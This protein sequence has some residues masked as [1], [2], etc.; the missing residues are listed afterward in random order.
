MASRPVRGS[1]WCRAAAR[2]GASPIGD[3]DLR[4][5]V[6][7]L[8]VPRLAQRSWSGLK[9]VYDF[10]GLKNYL[11]LLADR[12]FHI[13]IRNTLLFTVPFV[14]GACCSGSSWPSCST[15]GFRARAFFRGI[16]LF[17]MA[18][19]LH[20]HR[21]RLALA[22]EPRHRRPA[23]PGSTCSST[24]LGLDFLQ[25][26]LVSRHPTGGSPPSPC[27]PSGRCPATP[28]RSILAGLRGIPEEAARGR[29]RGRR[30]RVCSLY[31]YVI[32]P[33]LRPVTLTALIIL[34]HISLKV[35]DLIVA[36]AGKQ[37]SRSTCPPSTCGRRPSTPRL[38]PGAAIAIFM[39]RHRGGARHPVPVYSSARRRAP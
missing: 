16:Y 9:P 28:W 29:P 8:V 5:R 13:D 22:D 30:Q 20:R 1:H 27:R 33:L 36:I 19:S 14:V 2:P 10:V 7:R 26:P 3:G 32:L 39:L 11:D 18:I 37:L 15:S 12:R 34:G 6:H 24:S 17:P 23:R 25:Q 38:R 31:R 35:F 21:R 4:L